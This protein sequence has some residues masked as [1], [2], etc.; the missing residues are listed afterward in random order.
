LA[1]KAMPATEA[2]FRKP[3]LESKAIFALLLLAAGSV[4]MEAL[5]REFCEKCHKKP[6]TVTHNIT[7]SLIL[8]ANHGFTI[9]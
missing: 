7:T 8:L 5:S 6:L 2:R 9:L 3:R 4:W 1:E